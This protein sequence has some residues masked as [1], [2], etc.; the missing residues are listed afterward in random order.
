ML[1]NVKLYVNGVRRFSFQGSSTLH[2]FCSFLIAQLKQVSFKNSTYLRS[3][4]DQFEIVNKILRRLGVII[5][6]VVVYF[7]VIVVE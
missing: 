7:T 5:V 4:I 2:W 6:D 1:V 3:K